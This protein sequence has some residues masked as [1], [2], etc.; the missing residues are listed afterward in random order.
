[1]KGS[2]FPIVT[3]LKIVKQNKNNGKIG[4]KKLD[5]RQTQ[6]PLIDVIDYIYVIDLI[7]NKRDFLQ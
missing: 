5:T 6:S 7:D 4:G 3:Q 1:M 2:K